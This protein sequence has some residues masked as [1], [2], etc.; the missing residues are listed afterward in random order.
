MFLNNFCLN[1]NFGLNSKR[2]KKEKKKRAHLGLGQNQP[3][4][5]PSPFP[6]LTRPASSPLLHV[7]CAP[8]LRVSDAAASSSPRRPSLRPAP[9]AY[10][11]QHRRSLLLRRASCPRHHEHSAVLS[12]TTLCF[13]ASVSSISLCCGGV[14][15]RRAVHPR[16]SEQGRELDM[17]AFKAGRAPARARG[18]RRRPRRAAHDRPRL[19]PALSLSLSMDRNIGASRQQ[20]N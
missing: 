4:R 13:A 9:P 5:F 20:Q 10:G 6:S 2:K 19:P 3:A 7:A 8:D 14:R 16:R 1:L 18:A 17:G 12:S 11:R 15:P